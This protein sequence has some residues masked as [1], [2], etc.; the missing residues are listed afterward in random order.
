MAPLVFPEGF[1]LVPNEERVPR[2]YFAI[3]VE[4]NGVVSW[5]GKGVPDASLAVA[6]EDD[7]IEDI[8]CQTI[9]NSKVGALT[10]SID[11][12]WVVGSGGTL[13]PNAPNIGEMQAQLMEAVIRQDLEMMKF[14]IVCAFGM[15]GDTGE[16]RAVRYA[17]SAL[18]PQTIGGPGADK[19]LGMP[20]STT[21]A[22]L[23]TVGSVDGMPPVN[24]TSMFT[25][26]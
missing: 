14:P 23:M 13:A 10:I 15:A 21:L 22:G 5:F 7:I 6:Y 18:R 8:L 9:D 26:D 4:L 1:N 19:N 20:I 2:C 24:M 17:E 12:F 3:G 16:Y 11:P 25:Q